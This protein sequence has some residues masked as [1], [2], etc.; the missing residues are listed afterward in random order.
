MCA[1]YQLTQASRTRLWST[2]ETMC[3]PEVVS[4]RRFTGT[5][6]PKAAA[7]V[8]EAV[9]AVKRTTASTSLLL[10]NFARVVRM[11]ILLAW[12]GC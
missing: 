1:P 2:L 10:I 6:A 12:G 3:G 8:P 11:Q 4:G 7:A 5:R 9:A